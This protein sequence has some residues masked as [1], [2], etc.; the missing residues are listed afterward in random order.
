LL[1]ISIHNAFFGAIIK[2]WT[3]KRGDGIIKE[4][5]VHDEKNTKLRRRIQAKHSKFVPKREI[6]RRNHERIRDIKFDVLQMGE[7]I[8]GSEISETESMT[9]DEIKAMQKRL[10][11]LEEENMI[12][13]KR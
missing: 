8:F 6:K 9:M 2:K 7:K 4:R 10:A 13:K 5:G 1:Y 12:L 3:R 11:Q